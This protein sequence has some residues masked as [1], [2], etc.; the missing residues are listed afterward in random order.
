MVSL[1]IDK[2][3]VLNFCDKVLLEEV[4]KPK[5]ELDRYP[6]K[7]MKS[8]KELSTILKESAESV[9]KYFG[10]EFIY[11]EHGLEI[12]PNAIGVELRLNSIDFSTGTYS[13]L[14]KHHP[15][16]ESEFNFVFTDNS[17]ANV[18][19]YKKDEDIEEQLDD[20]KFYKQHFK[21]SKCYL[22]CIPSN[23]GNKV[24]LKEV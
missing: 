9:Y 2:G 18:Y 6:A 15:V 13:V 20:L 4:A 1:N 17:V 3:G 8:K 10:V 19:C 5:K 7:P 11:R 24:L 21:L 22:I 14:Y 23:E 12:F 16:D